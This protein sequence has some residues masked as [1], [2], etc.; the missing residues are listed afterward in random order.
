MDKAKTYKYVLLMVLGM[1]VYSA[2]SKV[3]V[4]VDPQTIIP[5]LT[6]TLKLRCSV[7]SEP[8]EIIGRRVVTSSAVSET[9]TTPA[10][11]SHVTSIIITRM[12]PETRVNV[13]VATVSSF[14]P[15]TAKVDLGKISVTGST[16]PT[17]GNGEKGFLELTWDHPLEDQDGVYICEIYAL[18]ALLHP[19]SV[20]VSTQVK[21]AAATLTD[22]VKYISD[23]DKHIETLQDRVHQLEDQISAQELKEQ[24]HTEGLIQKFQMLNGDIHRLEIITG[25][26]T[27]QNIQTGNITCS[28]NAGD[29]TIKFQKKYASVPDVFLAF[30]SS[31]SNS[32][33]VT[34]SKSS[35]STDGF[36]LRCASSSSSISNV[37]SWMAIDN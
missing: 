28:N 33:S 7:T 27:G 12:H 18:N 37:I 3:I 34:L 11:V 13:T 35:V 9:S 2:A 19:E 31:S 36:Q 8:V 6:K 25:N 29:I 32:Y 4:T 24:N 1:V 26:L 10:D 30:S 21:T 5:V 15:P 17:S 16:N 22:L 23:N 14:D 20:T